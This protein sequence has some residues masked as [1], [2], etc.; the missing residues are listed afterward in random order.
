M[1]RPSIALLIAAVGASLLTLPAAQAALAPSSPLCVTRT[2]PAPAALS[3]A[4]FTRVDTRLRDYTLRSSALGV[5]GT[6]GMPVTTHVMVLLPPGYDPA[7]GRRYP[8]LLL[9]HGHG[10]SYRDWAEHHVEQ[11]VDQVD[12]NLIVVMPDGGYDGFYSDWYGTDIDG[13]TG[14]VPPGWETYHLAELLPWVDNSFRTIGTRSGRAVAGLS[15]GGFGAMSY[16][17]RHPDLFALAGSFSGAVDND[18]AW[19][20]G[21]EA[22]SVAANAPDRKEPDNCIWGDP[23]TSAVEWHTHDPTELAPNLAPVGVSVWSG[24]GLPD[25]APGAPAW[26]PGAGATEAGIDQENQ[27]FVGALTAAGQH[28]LVDFY[29]A[30]THDWFYWEHDLAQFL[31]RLPAGFWA[32][33]GRAPAMF[34]YRSA[35]PRFSVWGWSFNAARS[36]P[37]FTYLDDVGA[38]G[39]TVRG[40][41]HLTV[42]PPFRLGPGAQVTVTDTST[43]HVSQATVHDGAFTVGLGAARQAPQTVFGAAGETV[44]F[45]TAYRV[46]VDAKAGAA[47]PP[48]GLHN[49][50]T[51]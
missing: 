37:E 17:A 22:Q 6:S 9:L 39:F 2:A 13:H 15:M 16:A 21:S 36:A 3:V 4:S 33:K 11:I 38:H 45:P 27:A 28:P 46:E 24:D 50:T 18:L 49:W 42:T 23:V 5:Q 35:E 12:P 20:I 47:Q 41:G 43:G 34:S 25:T 8:M 30:G 19:P 29:G 32:G 14:S 31:G 7:A 1:P 40:S 10:G 51:S 26:N 48:V 44:T